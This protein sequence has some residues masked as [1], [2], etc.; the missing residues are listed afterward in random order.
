MLRRARDRVASDNY[1][2]ADA[3]ALP[4]AGDSFDTVV[5]WGM[6]HIFGAGSRF[7]AQIERVARSGALVM[8]SSLILTDRRLG[9]A[10]LSMLHKRSETAAPAGEATVA[11]AFAARFK[12]TR[13]ERTGSML[14]LMGHR[15]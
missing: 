2:Q 4:F 12:P 14:T 10:M 7:M 5:S 15:R 13:I 8:M 9:N 3:L 11:A 1:L 6:L